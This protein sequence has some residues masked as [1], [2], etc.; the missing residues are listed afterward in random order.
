MPADPST[1]SPRAVLDASALLAYLQR[2]R[3][4]AEVVPVLEDSAISAV[5]LSE[6]LQ[7]AIAAGVP[8]EGFEAD[9][10]LLQPISLS[11]NGLLGE[12]LKQAAV[13]FGGFERLALD[14]TAD[15]RANVLNL[16]SHRMLMLTPIPTGLLTAARPQVIP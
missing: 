16:N 9:G 10:V 8:T 1:R 12:V 14:Q 4:H 15:L 2:E 5:N 11:G 6:V 7:K 3:G 13:N